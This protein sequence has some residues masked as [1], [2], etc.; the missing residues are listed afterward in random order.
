MKKSPGGELD[1]LDLVREIPA[2][3]MP[4]PVKVSPK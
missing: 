2:S 3:E 4:V 1:L